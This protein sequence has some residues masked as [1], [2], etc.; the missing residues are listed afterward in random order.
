MPKRARERTY[1]L[2]VFTGIGGEQI[3]RRSQI[4]FILADL[5]RCGGFE[6]TQQAIRKEVE[7]K[8]GCPISRVFCEKWGFPLIDHNAPKNTKAPM[9]SRGLSQEPSFSSSEIP[10]FDSRYRSAFRDSPRS[11][12]AWLLFPC[13]RR[14]AS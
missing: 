14:N 2:C 11:R 3:S 13:A 5:S 9:V 10:I 4:R 8:A 7:T 12:A 6:P 1:K